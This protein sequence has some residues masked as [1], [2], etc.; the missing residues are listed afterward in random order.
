MKILFI[1]QDMFFRGAQKVT[2]QLANGFFN[3]GHSVTVVVSHVHEDIRRNNPGKESF[4]LESGIGL[5]KLPFRRAIFNVI[6]FAIMIRRMKP[7]VIIANA[8]HYDLCSI[9]AVKLAVLKIPI[10]YIEHCL[11]SKK[12]SVLT[13]C[14]MRSNS[15]I[16]AVSDGVKKI[17]EELLPSVVGKVLRIYNPILKKERISDKNIHPLLLNKKDFVFVAAGGL[18]YSKGWFHLINAFSKFRKINQN[19]V[20]IIFGEGNQKDE[21]IAL[22]KNLDLQE[23][24]LLGG[25]TDN[26]IGNFSKADAYISASLYETFGMTIIEAMSVDLPIIAIDCPVGP[27]EILQ[28]G[29][30]GFLVK[31][32]DEEQMV[33][34]MRRVY[35]GERKTERL[36]LSVFYEDYVL[37]EYEK[38][39]N[40]VL[41]KSR[42]R[43]CDVARFC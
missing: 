31:M 21:L 7:D 18:F 19:G 16:V 43:K 10:V 36:D 2:A 13:K 34:V 4:K 24:V 35:N 23:C 27:R 30:Y 20:L 22:I 41:K 38:I 32:W 37:K 3:M 14:F 6:P 8:G 25:H 15:V 40:D 29:K 33:D 39:L 17:F 1:H 9:L 5:L 11:L 42:R 26:L 12:V 28:D